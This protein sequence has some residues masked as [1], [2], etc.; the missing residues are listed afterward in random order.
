MGIKGLDVSEEGKE[1]GEK[2][3]KSAATERNEQWI[4]FLMFSGALFYKNLFL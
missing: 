1:K 3:K 4:C 2:N